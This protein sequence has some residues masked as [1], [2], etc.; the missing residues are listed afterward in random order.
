MEAPVHKSIKVYAEDT[1]N[2]TVTAPVDGQTLT[3]VKNEAVEE[4]VAT[5][6]DTS[7]IPIGTSAA[8]MNED[9]SIWMDRL[10]MSMTVN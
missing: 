4:T 9:G 2:L 6:K 3:D 1:L 10:Q 7:E 5:V 8:I